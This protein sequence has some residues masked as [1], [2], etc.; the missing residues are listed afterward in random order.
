M[1]G[2]QTRKAVRKAMGMPL[3]L[4]FVSFEPK[5]LASASVGQVGSGIVGKKKLMT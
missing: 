1:F 5:P 4:A 3:E 2:S